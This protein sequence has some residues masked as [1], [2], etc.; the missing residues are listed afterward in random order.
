VINN[1]I[2]VENRAAASGGGIYCQ[3]TDPIMLNNIFFDNRADSAGGGLYCR[4]SNPMITN[5]IFYADSVGWP[6]PIEANEIIVESGSPVVEYCDIQGG[7]PGTGNIDIDPLFRNPADGDLHLMAM[8]CGDSLDSP[9]IDAGSP[10]Y[11]DSLLDCSWGL[12]TTASDMGAYGGGDTAFVNIYESMVS[13][14]D[15]FMLLCNYP[16]PFNAKTT[17]EFALAKP[18]DVELT[19]YDIAGAK[20]GTIGRQGLE[21]GGHAIVWDAEDAASGVY[22]ARLEAGGYTES[23]KMVLLK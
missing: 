6:T 23:I 12:G 1:N 15:K 18:G 17:I 22:F 4:A 2:V 20:V 10:Y 7:W 3:A 13:T 11:V 16:N 8:Y 19:I 9:C 21:A 5:T 14:P